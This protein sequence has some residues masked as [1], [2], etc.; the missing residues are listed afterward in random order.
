MANESRQSGRRTVQVE[1]RYDGSGL[2]A[3]TRLSDMSAIGLH[4]EVTTPL[5]I[6]LSLGLSFT[7]PDGRKVRARGVVV[8]S[9]PGAGM[10][11]LFTS[12][13]EADRQRIAEL[14][15]LEG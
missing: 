5:P 10:A 6:G 4:L 7:L 9:E 2:R 14:A 3:Q 1:V 8:R 11:V 15:E 12:I 13:N